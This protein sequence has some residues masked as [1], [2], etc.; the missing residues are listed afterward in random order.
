MLRQGFKILHPHIQNKVNFIYCKLSGAVQAFHHGT[1][2][3][4]EDELFGVDQIITDS[5]DEFKA[6][7]DGDKSQG[8]EQLKSA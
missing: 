7:I 6:L 2:I 4:T 8:I 3:L 5:L 1:G